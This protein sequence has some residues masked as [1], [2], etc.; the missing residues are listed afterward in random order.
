VPIHD[1]VGMVGKAH[2]RKGGE[3]KCWQALVAESKTYRH[4]RRDATVP[5]MNRLIVNTRRSRVS[6]RMEMSYR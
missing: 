3:P 6:W 5:R 2:R 4:W 1:K